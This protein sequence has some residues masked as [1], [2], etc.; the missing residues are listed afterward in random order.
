VVIEQTTESLKIKTFFPILQSLLLAES[1]GCTV[2]EQLTRNLKVKGS[3]PAVYT[4]RG[5]M[6]KNKRQK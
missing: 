4:G 3:N 6:S 5:K 1:K 2:V